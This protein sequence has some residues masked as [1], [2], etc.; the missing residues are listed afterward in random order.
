MSLIDLLDESII[1][2]PLESDNK[3][4]VIRELVEVLAAAG[5]SEMPKKSLM[6]SLK[7]KRWA[8]PVWIRE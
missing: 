4:E 3:T 7:G 2:V 5:R 1:K 6:P 8:V